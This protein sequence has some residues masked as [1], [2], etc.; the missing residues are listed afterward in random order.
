[1]ANA[2]FKKG[3]TV[4][5][6]STRFANND[7]EYY[8]AHK[9]GEL[10][11]RKEELRVISRV[12]DSCGA[13]KITFLDRGKDSVFGRSANAT[14]DCFFTTAAEAF[15]YLVKFKAEHSGKGVTYVIY[16]NVV[17]DDTWVAPIL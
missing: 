1:M 11:E 7:R 5:Y 15:E 6:A 9:K 8:A 12:V 3:Q 10:V 16:P 13:K 14:A 4:F 17:G 2:K